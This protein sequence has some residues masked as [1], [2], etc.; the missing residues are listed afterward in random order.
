MSLLHRIRREP[1]K[2]RLLF[3]IG[4]GL[5]LTLAADP[6]AWAADDQ[7]P[8]NVILI[9][10]DDLGISDLGVYGSDY[11]RTPRLDR[12]AAEGMRFTDAYAAS[13]ICSP[14]RAALL[15]GRY[16]H[17]V[18]LTD[19]LPWDRLPENPRLVPPNHLKE[20]PASHATYAKSLRA[21]GYRTGL[22][23][24]WH[25]GNEHEFFAGGKH[26]DYGFDEAYDTDY[27]QIN[28]VD[29]GVDVLTEKSLAF[30]ENN[31]DRPFLL[32]LHHH[33]PHVP[34]AVPPEY[35]RRYDDVP[36]G[37]RHTNKKYAAMMSHLD[38]AVGRVL[39]KLD[40]LDL[41]G[42]TVVI[43][44]SDNGAFSGET[45]NLPY[46]NG[47]ATLYEGGIRV[48]LIVRWPGVVQPGTVCDG[49]TISTDF[50][51][52]VLDAAGL[53]RQPEAHLDG[54]SLLPW[55]RGETP[56]RS[57]A[58]YWHVPHYRN[59]GPQ[60]AVRDGDWKLVHNHEPDTH[61]LYNLAS[62]PGETNGLAAQQPDKTKELAS[63]LESHLAATGAQRMRP[64]P[65]WDAGQPHGR[66]WDMGTH[67]PKQGGTHR[68]VTD[69]EYPAW[70]RHAEPAR[71]DVKEDPTK[72]DA[73]DTARPTGP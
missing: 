66:V 23:G 70:F 44:T 21:A 29:K 61:E 48:P 25:L 2:R 49:V 72:A 1:P 28:N 10:T 68:V 4:L 46:R 59:R 18:H 54:Q 52:T 7:A 71:S 14:T 57:R 60:S 40:E 24:K 42:N 45:S 67:Y 17:R 50:F 37:E 3:S 43:F 51:P 30:L 31:R 63:Q 9:L 41:A 69:R 34:L 35:E 5:L 39:D 8:M 13:S 22:I 19:S 33:T 62:D 26:R 53:P 12:L 65:D 36:P 15:T 47:K 20:L 73:A 32:A 64:N 56:D 38:D 16:P 11:Y 58:V 27:G 55:L 6:R